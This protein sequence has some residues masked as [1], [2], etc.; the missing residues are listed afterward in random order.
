MCRIG[1][2]PLLQPLRRRAELRDVCGLLAGQVVQMKEPLLVLPEPRLDIGRAGR[3]GNQAGWTVQHGAPRH[4]CRQVHAWNAEEVADPRDEAVSWR[5]S[6]SG[7]AHGDLAGT[8]RI[9]RR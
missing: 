7:R 6:R 8:R 1:R 4:F 3:A 5:G 2:L 9:G